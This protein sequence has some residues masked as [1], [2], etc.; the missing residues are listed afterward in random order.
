MSY[1]YYF[2]YILGV[3]K[4]NNEIITFIVPYVNKFFG[5]P[6]KQFFSFL[7]SIKARKPNLI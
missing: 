1:L 3:S 5:R 7:T 6:M 4:M 2:A